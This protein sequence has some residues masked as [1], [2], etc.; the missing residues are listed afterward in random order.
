MVILVIWVII[1]SVLAII[2]MWV[3]KIQFKGDGIIAPSFLLQWHTLSGMI[4][5][6]IMLRYFGV[7]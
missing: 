6:L 2:I 5:V 4:F 3:L 1:S 7:I